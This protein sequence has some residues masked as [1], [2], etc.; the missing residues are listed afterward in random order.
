MAGSNGKWVNPKLSEYRGDNVSGATVRQ[1]LDSLTSYLG[2][3]VDDSGRYPMVNNEQAGF[4]GSRGNATVVSWFKI[5]GD[6]CHW[7]GHYAIGS[8]TGW[9]AV[10]VNLI[11]PVRWVKTTF[12]LLNAT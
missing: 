12:V 6:E 3:W 9:A 4:G 10:G 7:Y 5:T 8:T 1:T 2:G 11:P